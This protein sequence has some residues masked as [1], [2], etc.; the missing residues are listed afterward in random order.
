MRLDRLTEVVKVVFL[1]KKKVPFV[2]AERLSFFI[3]RRTK[4]LQ[5]LKWLIANNPLYADVEIDE[6]AINDL[7]EKGLPEKVYETITFSGHVV[8]DMVEHSR[9]DEPDDSGKQSKPSS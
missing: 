1:S 5:A 7:P 2:E 3:V 6:E 9:Y 8:E 4:V